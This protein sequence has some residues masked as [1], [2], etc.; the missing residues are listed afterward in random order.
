MSGTL[1]NLDVNT[2]NHTPRSYNYVMK[3]LIIGDSCVGKSCLLLRFTDG[4]FTP[5][6]ISTIGIDFRVRTI[7]IGDVKIKAQIWDTAGQERFRTI[8]TAYYRGAQGILLVYDVTNKTTFNNVVNWIRQ[9]KSHA[10]EN[11]TIILVGNKCDLTDNREVT[12]N[13][14]KEKADSYNCKFFETSAKTGF[15]VEDTFMELMKTVHYGS[16]NQS[17]DFSKEKLQLQPSSPGSTTCC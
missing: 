9:L 15:S 8:T 7:P 13:E 5:S 6:F 17:T 14:G 3:L 1:S 10:S 4:N 12:Y 2:H 16:L 11:V